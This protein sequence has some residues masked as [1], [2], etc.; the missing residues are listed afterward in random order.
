MGFDF[1]RSWR[2]GLNAWR[3]Q[4]APIMLAYQEGRGPCVDDGAYFCGYNEVLIQQ[5]ADS[6]IE[7]MFLVDCQPDEPNHYINGPFRQ[8]G[9]RLAETCAEAHASGRQMYA[10]YLAAT[11]MTAE[12]FPLVLFRRAHW[13]FVMA[14][15]E[16]SG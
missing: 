10:S 6:S 8:A 5:W 11:R 1:M 15:P 9:G 4:D 2:M 7:A 12:Q 16:G 13:D 14:P 3:V